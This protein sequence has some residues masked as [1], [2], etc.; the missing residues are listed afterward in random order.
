MVEPHSSNFRV[1]TTN[2][3]GV[4]IFR[5]FTVNFAKKKKT[6]NVK[7]MSNVSKYDT[8]FY[9]CYVKVLDIG[10]DQ[11]WDC[12]QIYCNLGRIQKLTGFC[13]RS[14]LFDGQK[15]FASI[16]FWTRFLPNCKHLIHSITWYDSCCVQQD[17][18]AS[19]KVNY[20]KFNCLNL[21][22]NS[23]NGNMSRLVT[24]PTMWLCA[25]RW[26]RSAWA[27]AQSDQSLRCP[28]EESFGS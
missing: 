19:C 26:L 17:L 12:K 16:L 8:K 1:I 15:R 21:W 27:S 13:C 22:S 5:K 2:V 6:M 11:I 9:L 10:W 14:V 20:F 24:K 25:Q 7:M 18:A 23:K 3:S 28:H 4:R